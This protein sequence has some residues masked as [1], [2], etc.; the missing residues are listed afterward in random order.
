MLFELQIKPKQF[1][2]E[3]SERN[4]SYPIRGSIDVVRVFDYGVEAD[5]YKSGSVV[6]SYHR[7]QKL[8]EDLQ[9]SIYSYVIEKM[10]GSAPDQMFIQPLEFSSAFLKENGYETLRKIR[11]RV[12]PRS[13][14][15]YRDIILLNRDIQEV[16]KMIVEKHRFSE[17]EREKW[18]PSSSF[19]KKA[20]F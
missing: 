18:M 12:P 17:K 19:G 16:T 3:D 6:S 9:M 5:D 2:L 10:Y 4:T 1:A 8:V 13:Q 11:E 14:E 20:H 7:W 15:H